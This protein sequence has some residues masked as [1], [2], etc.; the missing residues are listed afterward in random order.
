LNPPKKKADINNPDELIMWV[1]AQIESIKTEI[2]WIKYTL[3]IVL[4]LLATLIGIKV[5]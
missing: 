3:Y 4:A 1:V 5:W 2:K